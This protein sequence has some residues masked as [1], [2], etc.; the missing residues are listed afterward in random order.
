MN[1]QTAV[2]IRLMWIM[3]LLKLKFWTVVLKIVS[4]VIARMNK[5]QDKL[6]RMAMSSIGIIAFG[7]VTVTRVQQNEDSPHG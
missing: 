3:F 5:L 1:I 6:A 7:T 4:G 2:S